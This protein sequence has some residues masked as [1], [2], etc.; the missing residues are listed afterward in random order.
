MWIREILLGVRRN[1]V[2]AFLVFLTF[3]IGYASVLVTIG[4]VEG[5]RRSI[6]GDLRNLGVDCIACLN[7]V[8]V[9]WMQI[10]EKK[11]R[12]LDRETTDALRDELGSTV[13]AVIPFKMELAGVL[14]LFRARRSPTYM[15]TT[16]EFGGVLAGGMLAGRFLES[17]DQFGDVTP[18][19]VD[20]ALAREL[21]GKEEG[22][23][24]AG[25]VGQE[26]DTKRGEKTFRARVVGVMRDPISLRRQLE[27]FDSSAMARSISARRLEFKNIYL[28][29]EKEEPSGVIVQVHD[30]DEVEATLERVRSWLEARDVQPFYHVQKQW[31]EFLIEMVDR[32]SSL[33][34]F[35]W[36]VNLLVVLLLNS[37]I[38]TLALEER[39]SEIALRRVE[40]ATLRDVTLPVVAEGVLLA[41]PALP[42]G[43]GIAQGI[44]RWFAEPSLLWP[45]ILPNAA[46]AGTGGLILLLGALT[47]FVPAR[48]IARLSP[49]RVLA[50][51]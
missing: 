32:F 50:E 22:T 41:V 43:Y 17:G 8:R 25:M 18:V 37:T 9:G 44:L 14:D 23:D 19:V 30:L 15:V 28:P 34:H 39:Y 35:F 11:G 5:G 6:Q 7:P 20:E 27:M 49:A 33:S 3:A 47:N 21:L 31:A 40:G 48:R 29:M 51:R 24:P 36:I 13:R 16:P 46:V 1:P 38:S 45:A 42:V 2:R 26:F 10:G 4:T 12:R